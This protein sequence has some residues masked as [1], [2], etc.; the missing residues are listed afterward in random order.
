MGGGWGGGDIIYVD[1]CVD[2]ILLKWLG[3]L[4]RVDDNFN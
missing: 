1:L 3:L 2:I 4:C